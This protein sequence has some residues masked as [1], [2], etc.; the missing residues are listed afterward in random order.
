M[1]SAIF[2]T[3]RSL[4]QLIVTIPLSHVDEIPACAGARGHRGTGREADW[5]RAVHWADPGRSNGP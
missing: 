4:E 2:G 1:S 5:D 3:G